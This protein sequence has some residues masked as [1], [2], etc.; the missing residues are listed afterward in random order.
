MKCLQNAHGE[1][2]SFSVHPVLQCRA[3]VGTAHTMH[4]CLTL[5][6]LY[7]NTEQLSVFPKGLSEA[8]W[9]QSRVRER[10]CCAKL[11]S[12]SQ[13]ATLRIRELCKESCLENSPAN[14]CGADMWKEHM[15]P[16]SCPSQTILDCSLPFLTF[17]Q[18][19]RSSNGQ[20]ASLQSPSLLGRAWKGTSGLLNLEIFC[21]NALNLLTG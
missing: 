15:I 19:L 18:T 13:P 11:S 6:L 5:Q 4:L 3:A 21:L 1:A 2:G 10:R 12:H 17:L 16:F 8:A 7:F 20:A 14:S 9:W